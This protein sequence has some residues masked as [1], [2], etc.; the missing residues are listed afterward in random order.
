VGRNNLK[1]T[2]RPTYM[3]TAAS[4]KGRGSARIGVQDD[5]LGGGVGGG[6][7][8][9]TVGVGEGPGHMKTRDGRGGGDGAVASTAARP[10][11]QATPAPSQKLRGAR[12]RRARAREA[13]VQTFVLPRRDSGSGEP[14]VEVEEDD[15]HPA[16]GAAKPDPRRRAVAGAVVAT[17]LPVQPGGS[18]HPGTTRG[19][20]VSTRNSRGLAGS[21]VAAAQGTRTPL[22][23]ARYPVLPT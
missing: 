14:E 21:Q 19:V 3:G 2:H 23:G 10:S 4:T 5:D 7:G 22:G 6:G 16:T 13:T 8:G 9:A 18:Q 15:M 20:S 11:T 17:G 12:G 1:A